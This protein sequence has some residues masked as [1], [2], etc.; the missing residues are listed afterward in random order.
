MQLEPLTVVH[1]IILLG[2]VIQTQMLTPSPSY[3]SQ[4]YWASSLSFSDTDRPGALL[5]TA[6][7]VPCSLFV[8]VGGTL[9]MLDNME[10]DCPSVFSSITA[11]KFQ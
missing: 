5:A 11:L 4:P 2:T 7:A 8:D 10:D 6:A 3:S 9:P 1:T